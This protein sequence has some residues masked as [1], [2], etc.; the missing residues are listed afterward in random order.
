MLDWRFLH[1]WVLFLLPVPLIWLAWYYWRGRGLRPAVV[2]SDSSVLAAGTRTLRIRLAGFLPLL[3][4]LVVILGIVALARP[5]FGQVERRQSALG[6][7]IALALDIS[8]TMDFEDFPPSR[9]AVAKNVMKEFVSNRLSDR[10]SLVIFGTSAA[11]LCP[12][13][14]DIGA[15]T[16]FIDFVGENTF[17]D[18]QRRTAI[19]DGLALAVSRLKDGDA[20]SKVVILLTDGESNDGRIQPLQAAE[21]ANALG[22][23][24]YT[25]GVGSNQVIRRRVETWMG[26]QW[27]EVEVKLDEETL[28]QI[29][30][31]TG[32]KYFRAASPEALSKIYAEIDK[33]EKSEIEISEY[34]NYD[35]RFMWFWYPAVG[36][37]ALEFLLRGFW[38][39]RAP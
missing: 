19:G 20:K 3:R 12:P 35:E 15:V 27:Q 2:Y 37:L 29:A 7:D 25:I 39:G 22:I 1:P 11:V 10:I 4:A 26:P 8:E 33:L 14:Y 38:L 23:T 9:L 21:A 28:K 5:Q 32:G 16:N 18:E 6:I 36:L 24:V 31:I 13:T 30:D 17:S 34:D